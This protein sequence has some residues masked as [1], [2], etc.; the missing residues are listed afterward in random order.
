M[1]VLDLQLTLPRAEVLHFMGYREGASPAPGIE[2]LLE[3]SL[4][5]ARALADARGAWLEL[6]VDEAATVGLEAMPARSLIV[7]LVTA[8]AGIETAASRALGRG[9]AT[10]ALL[11]D[12]CGSAAAEEAADRLGAAIVATLAGAPLDDAPGAQAAPVSCRISP[13]YGQWPLAAQRS[14]F[15]RLPHEAL[16]VRLEPSLLMVPRKS[17]SFAMWLGAEARP[18]AG[19]SGCARCRL[20]TCIYRRRPMEAI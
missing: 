7:G 10:A 14:L 17:I 1:N 12:A 9:E 15:S 18:L 16:G 5:E 19:L 11:L 6:P 13:G 20:E 8:G 2:A 3:A 4:A